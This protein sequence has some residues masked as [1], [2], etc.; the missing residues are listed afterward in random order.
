MLSQLLS[1]GR[2]LRHSHL[3]EEKVENPL[4]P[5]NWFLNL[6]CKCTTVCF[7]RASSEKYAGLLFCPLYLD[8][9]EFEKQTQVEA[10]FLWY[11]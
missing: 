1:Q 4:A 7:S 3:Q 2:V 9:D 11:L 6:T 5:S 10:D 8:F